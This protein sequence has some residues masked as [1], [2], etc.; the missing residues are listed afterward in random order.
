MVLVHK[1]TKMFECA[2]L[3]G[4]IPI[5]DFHSFLLNFLKSLDPFRM[6]ASAVSSVSLWSVFWVGTI[7]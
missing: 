1:A 4:D 2:M 6:A 5:L 3:S 7:N